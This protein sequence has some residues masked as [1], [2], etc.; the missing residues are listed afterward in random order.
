[1]RELSQVGGLIDDPLLPYLSIDR[2]PR[3]GHGWVMANMV[4]GLDGTAAIHGRVGSLSTPRDF[5]LFRR[6]RGLADVV[7]VGASTVRQERYGPVSLDDDL[8][9]FRQQSGRGVPR[10]AVVSSSLDLDPALPVFAQARPEAPPIVLTTSTSD[11]SHLDPLP[12]EIVVAGEDRVDLRRA[13]AELARRAPGVILCEGGPSLLGELIAADLLDEYCLT[14]SPIVGGDPLPVI[15][16]ASI[17]D[18][19]R[20]ALHH[21]YTEDSTLFLNYLR[22]PQ[23]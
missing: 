7:L 22:E 10:I 17:T 11:T 21:V 8:A 15:N 18:P 20:F 4:A 23:S 19:A 14:I 9:A 1:M 12:V 13:L 6:L 2:Q 3:D 16:A 5:E